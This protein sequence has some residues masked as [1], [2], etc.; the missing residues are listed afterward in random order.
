MTS[1]QEGEGG[2][3]FCDTTTQDLEHRSVTEGGGGLKKCLDLH[4]VIYDSSLC[5][6]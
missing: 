4:D 5:E 3:Y 2:W 6:S 1:H